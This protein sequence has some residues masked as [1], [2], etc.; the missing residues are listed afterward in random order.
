[1]ETIHWQGYEWKLREDWGI[2]HPDFPFMYTDPDCVIVD[3]DDLLLKT[4][5]KPREFSSGTANFATGKVMSVDT[6]HFGYYRI[7]ATLPKGNYLW[8]AIWLYGFDSWPPEIDIMEG[9]TSGRGSYFNI[10]TSS[11]RS[12]FK[13]IVRPY[14]IEANYHISKEGGIGTDRVKV[15]CFENFNDPLTFEMVWLK[16]RITM[17][18]DGVC[19]SEISGDIMKHFQSPMRF[20][21]NNAVR[22]DHPKTSESVFKVHEFSYNTR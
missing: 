20:L 4:K 6:F 17:Y 5:I 7:T 14:K 21:I 13:S 8:P 18:C 9:Y 1:M 2:I 15:R 16:D 19:Y 12:F 11:F 10:S 22:K 3:N